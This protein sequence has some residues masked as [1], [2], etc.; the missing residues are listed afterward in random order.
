MDKVYV[1]AN[2]LMMTFDKLIENKLA[3]AKAAGDQGHYLRES[4][5]T[6]KAHAYTIAKDAIEM[7]IDDGK[8]CIRVEDHENGCLCPR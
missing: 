5:Y 6:G 8:H 2:Y 1:D 4:Y 7:C 3:I